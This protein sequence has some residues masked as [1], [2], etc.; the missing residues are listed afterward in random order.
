MS[1]IRTQF[2]GDQRLACGFLVELF[3]EIQY[4]FDA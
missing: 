3:Q 2:Y 4:I 1:V